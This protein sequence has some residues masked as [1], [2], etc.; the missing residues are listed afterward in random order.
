MDKQLLKR[1]FAGFL[2]LTAC[3]MLYEAIFA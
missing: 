2:A 3:Q 1:L